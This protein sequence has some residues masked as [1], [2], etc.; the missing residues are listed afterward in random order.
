MSWAGGVALSPAKLN[1]FLSVGPAEPSGMHP[2]CTRMQTVSLADEV[3]AEPAET[4]SVEF[5]PPIVEGPNTVEKALALARAV[6]DFPPLRVVVR[7]RVPMQSGLGGGSSNAGAVLRLAMRAAGR[8]ED[9][10]TLGSIAAQVG[11][12]SPFFLVGGLA[13]CTGWGQVVEAMPDLPESWL[14]VAMPSTGV[15]SAG[16]YAR[17]DALPRSLRPA[18]ADPWELS[19]DFEAVAPEASLRLIRWLREA[20][21]DRAGLTGSGAACFGRYA[22]RAG[23]EEAA[24]RCPKDAQAWPVRTLGREES[25]W[26]S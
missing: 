26:T 16:A 7:K 4:D 6:A 17:L 11:M 10:Q 24:A 21:A 8:P 20:G 25:L 1:L 12:D 5:E 9:A 14:V 15:S 18:P 22:G 19:N 3:L 23:A 13:E 2:V